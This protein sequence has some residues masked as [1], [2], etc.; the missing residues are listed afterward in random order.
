MKLP[1]QYERDLIRYQLDRNLMVEA[2]AGTGKTHSL[3][4]RMV[5]GVASGCY[6]VEEM[7]CVTFTRKAAAELRGRL[8]LALEGELR[9]SSDEARC[10]RLHQALADLDRMF[11]GT[12]HSFC[13]GLLREHP[14]R[15]GISPGFRE[16]E[17]GEDE[18][19]R[20]LVFCRTLEE[21]A[22]HR[23]LKALSWIKPEELL[24]ALGTVCNHP[25]ASFPAI[26][27][28]L[29]A[30]V[31]EPVD[32]F[33]LELEGLLP[34]PVDPR[35][36]CNIQIRGRRFLDRWRSANRGKL[37]DLVQLL[38]EWE[39]TPKM[40]M[41]YWAPTRAEQLAVRERVLERVEG[42]RTR[43][44][45]SFLEQWRAFLYFECVQFLLLVRER[46]TA[47]RRRRGL[48]SFGDLVTRAVELLRHHPCTRESRYRFLF[49][50]EFQD[51]DPLQAEVIFW[52]AAEPGQ[53]ETD[54]TR[55]R[56]RPGALFVV[57]DPKQSIYRF[58]SAD[59][60]TYSLVADRL[61]PVVRL[62]ASF[63]SLPAL[64][65]WSNR[66]FQGL[67]LGSPEQAAFSPLTSMR[68][69]EG[70]VFSLSESCYRYQDAAACEAPRIAEWIRAAVL[71]RGYRWGDFLV[72]TVRRDDLSHY[73]HALEV[74]GVP[75]EVTGRRSEG[76]EPVETLL[77][78][79]TVLGDPRD[80]VAMVGM[81][82]GPLFGLDDDTLFRH[83]QA[84]GAFTWWEGPGESAVNDALERLRTMR[85]WVRTLP[86]GAAVE[87]I[88]EETGLV[89][90]AASRPGGPSEAAELYRVADQ[91][92][93]LGK[94]GLLLPDALRE[95]RLQRDQPPA[96][97][98]GRK[99]VVRVMNLHQ[100]KGLEARVVFLASPTGGSELRAKTRVV[101]SGR[102]A[103]A[104]MSIRN[105]WQVFAQPADWP[106]H[107]Q[108]ELS[109][110]AAE[111]TRLLYVA[112]TRARELLVVSRWTGTHGSARRPWAPLEAFVSEELAEL[113]RVEAEVEPGS[114]DG[115]DEARCRWRAERE[116]ARLPS[117][118]RTSVRAECSE[119]SLHVW[120]P[121][122]P[123][124]AE[125]PDS[126]AMWGDLIHRL[127]E[128]VMRNPS[129]SRSDLQRLAEWYV[130]DTPELVDLIPQALRTIEKVKQSELWTRALSA[131]R[132]LVEVPFGVLAE[133]GKM[134]FGIL[135]LALDTGEGWELVD[136]KTDRQKVDALV[137]R[138]AE[139]VER[140]ARHW[141]EV[142]GE[143]V[144]FAGVFGVREGRLS[145]DL[146]G[147]R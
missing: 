140:Y 52:L 87:R 34:E 115:L 43:V 41:K 63:R 100:A 18:S 16:L 117:W 112:A 134:V 58:R 111:R 7:A 9:E 79:L 70:R 145:G 71:K 94:T 26:E 17:D 96:L 90:R 10:S 61:G 141:G 123:P 1:D 72:L 116:A 66:V 29:P 105:M 51:T 25:D 124:N 62:C 56:L 73:A 12:L 33:A 80:Q 49:V 83:R 76:T 77:E 36:T 47:E 138:Y 4:S 81:L 122:A 136:Y 20:H 31:W 92:R 15:A 128:Q 110:L 67:L 60:D 139:Q 93:R 85:A 144:S 24:E 108:A 121:P 137:R 37:F 113:P 106:Q 2:S 104:F 46:Y 75:V 19:L 133:E 129:L 120:I 22:G 125:R 57:G 118:R 82:R 130:L 119:G 8:Q 142:T 48:V 131:E 38:A 146:S 88:L 42:F 127:L 65:D 5:E 23:L 39:R 114:A 69:G 97:D 3:S 35:T 11:L 74:R 86:L 98:V 109:Y 30:L 45:L 89:A 68:E 84:G 54:W 95:I 28:E 40:V 32:A 126:G 64:C 50:D 27:V 143:E 59:I 135:D 14:T 78:L 101:R 55:L 99:D 44:V 6:R 13:A 102:A 132:R 91:I 147:G 53:D 21:P 103:Q 107:Q